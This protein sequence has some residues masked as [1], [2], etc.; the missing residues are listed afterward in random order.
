MTFAHDG[1]PW[2]VEALEQRIGRGK[3]VGESRLAIEAIGVMFKIDVEQADAFV[4][5]P[6]GACSLPQWISF[7]PKI[8]GH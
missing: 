2:F 5:S 4:G 1:N 8:N 7:V 3:P 6:P